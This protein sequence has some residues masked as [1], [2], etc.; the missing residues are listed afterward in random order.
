MGGF[1][2]IYGNIIGVEALH[3]FWQEC[4]KVLNDCLCT[5]LIWT[6]IFSYTPSRNGTEFLTASHRQL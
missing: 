4:V 1:I 2:K 5:L 6:G 3:V